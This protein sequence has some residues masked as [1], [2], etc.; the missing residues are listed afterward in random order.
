MPERRIDVVSD[1][2]RISGV[3]ANRE[4]A[5]CP[6]RYGAAAHAAGVTRYLAAAVRANARRRDG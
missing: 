2:A 5:K 1:V 4:S 6:K 3:E